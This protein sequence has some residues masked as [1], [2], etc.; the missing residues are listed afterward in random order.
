M[1]DG[2]RY[3]LPGNNTPHRPEMIGDEFDYGDD[4]DHDPGPHPA[5]YDGEDENNNDYWIN[6]LGLLQKS[7]DALGNDDED[8]ENHER[9]VFSVNEDMDEDLDME[10]GTTT[11]RKTR[12]HYNKDRPSRSVS[13]P[14]SRHTSA[15]TAPNISTQ[16]GTDDDDLDLVMY[17]ADNAPDLDINRVSTS[18]SP[19]QPKP[20]PKIE[21]SPEVT[22]T[23]EDTLFRSMNNFIDLTRPEVIDLTQV[24][25]LVVKK[26]SSG[27]DLIEL[28]D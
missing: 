8:F 9:M 21:P 10:D 3:L 5:R 14:R 11:A 16:S 7:A 28:E 26:H 15:E 17:T 19:R 23:N 2:H 22:I 12:H 24:K 25:D 1:I 6:E 13:I 20:E 4:Q 18:Q 27:I